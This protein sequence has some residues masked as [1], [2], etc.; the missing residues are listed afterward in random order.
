MEDE[1]TKSIEPFIRGSDWLKDGVGIAE[2]GDLILRDGPPEDGS[3]YRVASVKTWN[4]VMAQHHELIWEHKDLERRINAREPDAAIS[5]I[6]TK[7]EQ[8]AV[9]AASLRSDGIAG[10][11]MW[12]QSQAYRDAIAL[13]QSYFK[14]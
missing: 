14:P 5:E 2:N 12:G 9:E 3:N 7:L 8:H 4:Q 13:I 1:K 10:K 6:I 11:V